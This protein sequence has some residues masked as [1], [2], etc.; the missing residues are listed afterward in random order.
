[1]KLFQIKT[2]SPEVKGVWKEYKTYAKGFE[3]ALSKAKARCS[4]KL[5]ETVLSVEYLGELEN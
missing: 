2:E 5:N 3:T 4:K 1:M